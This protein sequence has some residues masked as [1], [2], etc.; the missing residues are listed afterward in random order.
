MNLGPLQGPPQGALAQEPR[1]RYL[2]AGEALPADLLGAIVYGSDA[3]R[4]CAHDPRL[5]P[6][7][8]PLLPGSA[9]IEAWCVPGAHSEGITEGLRWRAAGGFL[10]ASLEL[11]EAAHGGLRAAACN[12]YQR[13]LRA[14]P[15]LP[16][17]HILRIWNFLDAIN[18]GAGDAERYRLFCQGRAE[19]IGEA[20]PALPAASA[21]G[22][23]DGERVLQLVL[24]AGVANGVTVENPRQVPAFHYPRSYGPRSPS[25]ARAIRLPGQVLISGTASIVGHESLH[26]DDLRAQVHESFNNMLAVSEASGLRPVRLRGLKAYVRRAA[27]AAGVV[28]AARERPEAGTVECLV[29]ADVCRS[30]LLVEFESV[31]QRAPTS[32]STS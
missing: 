32:A 4:R 7:P 19:G 30:E 5:V 21:L 16:C 1:L 11:D 29:Q 2:A 26:P 17:P 18:E 23:N 10:V 24:L 6:V 25:F 15:L 12:A 9:A 3:R 28:A 20:W 13:L 8:L 22:R 27:D 31:A 14:Q